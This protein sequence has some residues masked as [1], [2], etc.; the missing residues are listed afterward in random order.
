MPRSPIWKPTKGIK[1]LRLHLG[2]SQ[3]ELG[4]VNIG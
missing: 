1:N 4:A 2:L 3:A